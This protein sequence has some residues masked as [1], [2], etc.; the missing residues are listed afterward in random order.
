MD[1]TYKFA[2][3]EG[4]TALYDASDCKYAPKRCFFI[5]DHYKHFFLH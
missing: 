3:K 4:D 1:V 2:W 5:T